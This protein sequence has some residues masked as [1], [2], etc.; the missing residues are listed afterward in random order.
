MRCTVI[1]E[2]PRVL[3]HMLHI[4]YKT[5]SNGTE[6]KTH[7]HTYSVA[8]SAKYLNITNSEMAHKTVVYGATWSLLE[9][10]NRY[11]LMQQHLGA[12]EEYN[13]APEQLL[14]AFIDLTNGHT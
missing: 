6:H 9:T 10:P 7:G 4:K 13:L 11:N 8:F 2:M 14:L 12:G 5:S 1:Q 3:S